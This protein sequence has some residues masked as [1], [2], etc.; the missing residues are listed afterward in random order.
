MKTYRNDSARLLFLC[1]SL[2]LILTGNSIAGNRKADLSKND[3]I[4]LVLRSK[5]ESGDSEAQ[6][7]LAKQLYQ[8]GP[9]ND[10]AEA[11]R[12]CTRS[13]LQ[14]N[15]EA[16]YWLGTFYFKGDGIPK[17]GVTA[18]KWFLISAE[19]NFPAAQYM[20]GLAYAQGDDEKLDLVEAYKWVSLAAKNGDLGA[21]IYLDSGTLASKMS[22]KEIEQAKQLIANFKPRKAPRGNKPL[23]LKQIINS[24]PVASGTGFFI[25]D[26]GFL[27]TND[28]VVEDGFQICVVTSEGPYIAKI[29]KSDSTNDF[30]LL[31]VDGKF[32]GL[33]VAESHSVGLGKS[34]F[35]V[36]Y[37]V[38]DLQGSAPKFA[39]GEIAALSG[40]SDDLRYFQISVPLQP[41]N[42]GGPLVDERGNVVGVVSAKLDARAALQSSGV[43]PEN[44]NY[45]VK[46]SFLLS[47]LESVP[48]VTAKLKE[49]NTKDCKFDDVV[50]SIEDATV[51]VLVY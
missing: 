23:S 19:R 44:V 2:I 24:N 29:I 8:V 18:N 31:K 6:L 37:P 35:T 34:V 5:A 13:A 45:A 51:L 50:K 47:F 30:A 15:A 4:L 41:G 1:S 10:D 9:C 39:K 32:S 46:S 16:Q 22:A 12:W 21:K 7:E 17:N 3:S 43:L 40:A 36:G 11:V 28:H 38:I 14:N 48:G 26:D 25:T 20:L 42:S 27:I 33:S 49:T